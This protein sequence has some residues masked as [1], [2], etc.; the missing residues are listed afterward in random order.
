VEAL[1]E[2][3]LR[4]VPARE[5]LKAAGAQGRKIAVQ[6]ADWLKNKCNLNEAYDLA[7]R[8]AREKTA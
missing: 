6:R 4:L 8:Y 2:A 7:I 5:Q 1:T 3:I